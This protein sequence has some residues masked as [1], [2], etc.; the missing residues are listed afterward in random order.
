[1]YKILL[2]EPIDKAG[3]KVLDG[4]A[5]VIVSP[6]RSEETVG[7]LLQ[8]ADALIVR[9]AT[10][11]TR[12]MIEKASRLKVISRTGGGLNNVDVEAAT[13][14]NVVVAGVKGAQDRPVAEHAVFL[15]G[16]LAKHFPYLDAQVRGGNFKSRFE[17]RPTALA[18]KQLG[19]IGLGRIGRIVAEICVKGLEMQVMSFDPYVDPGTMA[20]TGIQMADSMEDVIR[21]ADFLSLH[22]PVTGETQGLMGKEQ[23]A[24]MKPTAFV[25]N[26]SRGEI[27][28][29]TALVEALKSGQIAGAGL[30]VFEKEPPDAGNPLFEMENVIMTPHTAAL[31]KDTVAK[32]AEGSAQNALSVLNGKAP[33][34]SGNW[35]ILQNKATR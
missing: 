25:V 6:D 15:M 22:V 28:Q 12:D 18:G 29:E 11:I 7:K 27:I 4:K 16:A 19:L 35:D 26:T 3:M 21:N 10:Q 34:F 20:G 33:S 14:C 30:D 24:L 8:D 13:E 2:S 32:L 5:E 23:F 1:M 31:S 17:Y 9:T